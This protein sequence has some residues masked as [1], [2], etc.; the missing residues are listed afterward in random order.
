VIDSRRCYATRDPGRGNIILSR[1][2]REGLRMAGFRTSSRNLHF[3]CKTREQRI[4]EA[5]KYRSKVKKSSS[6]GNIILYKPVSNFIIQLACYLTAISE[7]AS[8]YLAD[9]RQVMA[10]ILLINLGIP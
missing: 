5:L 8:P 6:F 2:I 7:L 3:T 10:L 4:C 1:D 9:P